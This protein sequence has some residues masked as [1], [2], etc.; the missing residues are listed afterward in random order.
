MKSLRRIQALTSNI[1]CIK[2]PFPY[3]KSKYLNSSLILLLSNG[4]DVKPEEHRDNEPTE[5][6]EAP[7]NDMKYAAFS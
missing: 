6:L 1:Q 5:L 3:R 7:K 4:R 2:T